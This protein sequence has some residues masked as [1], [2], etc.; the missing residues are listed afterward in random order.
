[1]LFGT[2]SL[3]HYSTYPRN[4]YSNSCTP[5]DL[6]FR[7]SSTLGKRLKPGAVL[8]EGHS[9]PA[10]WTIALFGNNDLCPALQFRIVLLVD[11]FTKDEHYEIG[12]LLD[13]SRL[14][15]VGKLRTMIATPALRCTA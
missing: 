10:D 1:M 14:A 4:A 13:R 6:L 9:N 5:S 7:G 8:K 2:A 15:Q 3:S 11:F 12:I